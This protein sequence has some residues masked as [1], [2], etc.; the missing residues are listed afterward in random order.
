MYFGDFCHMWRCRMKH[1]NVCASIS[2]FWSTLMAHSVL[3]LWRLLDSIA[4][5]KPR[6]VTAIK[7]AMPTETVPATIISQIYLLPFEAET[8]NMTPKSA[9]TVILMKAMHCGKKAYLDH[10]QART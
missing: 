3:D 4:I 1:Y 6:T 2:S 10:K 5:T 9:R 7:M 8:G